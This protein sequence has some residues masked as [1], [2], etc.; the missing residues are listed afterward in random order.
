MK[1]PPNHPDGTKMTPAETKHLFEKGFVHAPASADSK[2]EKS[3][4]RDSGLSGPGKPLC[5]TVEIKDSPTMPWNLDDRG[6]RIICPTCEYPLSKNRDVY[7]PYYCSL[8]CG[9]FSL[10]YLIRAHGYVFKDPKLSATTSEALDKLLK[11]AQMI[12]DCPE[13]ENP[14]GTAAV[15]EITNH[16]NKMTLPLASTSRKGIPLWRGCLRYFPAALAGVAVVSRKGNEK[17]NPGEE[18]HH[19]RGKASDH[20]DCIVRHLVDVSDLIAAKAPAEQI[21]HEADQ[22]VW[23]ALAFSQELHEQIGGAPLAPGA[24]LPTT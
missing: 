15:P 9:R 12:R 19:A 5:P 2:P 8:R 24:K 13:I 17:H 1:L 6:R 3:D 21:L 16:L 22:M 20:G 23:R 10:Q 14:I 18:L 7:Y 4:L 11:D